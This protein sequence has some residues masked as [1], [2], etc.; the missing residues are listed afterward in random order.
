MENRSVYQ[1]HI[2]DGPVIRL[3]PNVLSVNCF[4]DG[5]KRIYQGG[6]PKTVFYSRGFAIYK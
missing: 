2:E 6:F 5:L 4:E 3:A 1:R